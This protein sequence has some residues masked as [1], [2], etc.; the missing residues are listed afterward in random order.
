MRGSVFGVLVALAGLAACGNGATPSPFGTGGATSGGAAGSAGTAGAATGGSGGDPSVGGACLDDAQCNDGIACTDDV[1]DHSIGRCRFS[2]VNER[3]ADEIYCNGVEVCQPGIGCRAG[4]P[5]QCS[6]QVSCTIDRCI[7][8]TRSCEHLARDA[9]GDGD[10]VWNCGGKDCDDT[11]PRVNGRAPEVCGNGRDDNCDG[12]VDEESCAAPAHDTCVDALVID[13]DGTYPLSLLA[14]AEDAALSCV[15]PGGARRDVVVALTVPE[16]PPLNVDVTAVSED[17]GLAL[18]AATSCGKKAVELG[19]DAAVSLPDGTAAVSRLLLR[20]L[21]P[22]AYPLYVSGL[23]DDDVSLRVAYRAAEPA[24]P[25]ETCGTALELPSEGSLQASLV[26]LSRDL[27][28]VCQRSLGDLVYRFELSEPHDIVVRA[29]PLDANGT[30]SLSLRNQECAAASSELDCRVGAP[31]RLFARSLPAGTYFVG[32]GASGPT[33]VELSLELLDASEPAVDQGC[34]APPPIPAG[35]SQVLELGDHEN[36]IASACLA[37]AV[38]A[39][40]TLTL[41]ERSDVLLVERLSAGDTGAL[42]LL[43]P[44]CSQKTSLACQTSRTSPVRA[45]AFGLAAGDYVAVA[46]SAVGSPVEL[47]AFTRSAAPAI[48]VAF[49]DGCDDAVTI[50]ETGGRFSGNTDNAHADFEAGCDYGGGSQGGAGD[51]MLKLSLPEPRR[52]ILDMSGSDYSTIL[53]VRRATDCPG[54]EVL[55]ACAPGRGE[56]RSFL[57]LVLPAGDYFVQIDGFAGASGHWVLD[58][59]LAPP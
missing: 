51:Q 27:S 18:A 45:R 25:N 39:T 55:H 12:Q 37:G 23:S 46:E 19:C 32:L 30:P 10:P 13:G 3:C 52:V 7:E 28:S 4:M 33:D 5:V 41:T 22:G 8:E 44:S 2:A 20:E 48:L 14:A 54:T 24:A 42:S 11:D 58:A 15:E 40:R 31:A 53:V 35:I 50:P 34:A 38:D 36:S 16:G 26:G 47:T 9:D 6:D 29:V 43:R 1:C 56:G 59:F 17:A 49:A 21:A 57:D